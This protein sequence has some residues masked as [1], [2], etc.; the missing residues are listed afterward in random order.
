MP[1]CTVEVPVTVDDNGVEYKTIFYA[2]AMVSTFDQQQHKM[3]VA[4]DWALIDILNN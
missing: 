1:T 3:G 4:L 2:G